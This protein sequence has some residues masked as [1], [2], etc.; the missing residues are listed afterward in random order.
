TQPHAGR[1]VDRVAD[2][3][4]DRDDRRLARA[5][6]RQ[7]LAVQ[8]HDVDRRDVAEAREAVLREPRVQDAASLELDR[9]PQRAAEPHHDRTLD[10][11]AQPVWV[12]DRAALERLDDAPDAHPPARAVDLDFRARRDVVALLDAAREADAAAGSRLPAA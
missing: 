5:G 7:V 2:R 8:Q 4:R 6:G 12:H 9:L 3:G 11:V 10:L 1:G